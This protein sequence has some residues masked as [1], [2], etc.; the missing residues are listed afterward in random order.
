MAQAAGSPTKGDIDILRFLSAVE[1]IES[2]LWLQYN[3]LGGIQDSE[4]PGGSGSVAYTNALKKLDE[5]MDQ[6]IH[7]NTEDEFSHHAFLNA[8]LEFLGAPA[9]DLTPFRTLK[10]SQATGANK[11][12]LRLTNLMG[13]SVDT[14][15]LTRYR[16]R[17][18][19]PDL[20]PT[21]VFP[22]AVP[23]L[24]SG[25]HTAI[26]RTDAD[27]TPLNHIQAIANTAAFH[28]ASIEQGGTS[29]YPTLALKVTNP[30]IL[31][32]LLSIG[33]TE[34]MHF[35]TWQDKAGNAI[36][37][38]LAPLTD[39]SLTFP[40]LSSA[41]EDFQPNLIMPE[42]CP[43]LDRKF[44]VCSIIRPVSTDPSTFGA[45]AAIKGLAA[46]G[47]FIGQPNAFFSAAIALAQAADAATRQC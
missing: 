20:D 6:Y 8:F 35:Q 24:N 42:P 45:V 12:A 29:L 10:G 32:I 14:S 40:D 7:D 43:F 19:N 27:L 1:Q 16:S 4:V 25:H 11:S 41:G 17:A 26:P 28:F 36:K 30:V 37:P 39:G 15:W 47:L 34:T 18:N 13:L 23:T 5:D 31:R 44:P 22:Q 21:F 38:D 3:E 2:D 9:V 33:P 46:S